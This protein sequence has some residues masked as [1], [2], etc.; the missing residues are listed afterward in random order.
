MST[1][2]VFQIVNTIV[3]PAWLILIFAPKQKWRNPVIYSFAAVMASVYAFYV[4]TGLNNF[5]PSSFGSLVGVK[6]LFTH[7]EA[8]LAGWVHYLVFDL[9]I[10][11][12][13]LNQSIKHGV[14]HYL[15]IPCLLLSFM[16]GPIGYLLFTIIKIS[17]AKTL[18]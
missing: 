10:G 2:D 15:V 5:D 7:D 13:I 12:W 1:T 17:K 3:L 18:A 8:V 6:A 14:K 9:L 16:F 11:N 4:L